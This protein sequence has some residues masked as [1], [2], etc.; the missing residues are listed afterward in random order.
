MPLVLIVIGLIMIVTGAQN[1]HAQFAAQVRSD[2]TGPG[3]FVYW[4]VSIG[5]VGSIGYIPKFQSFSRLF[6]ALIIIAFVLKNGGFIDKL[7]EFLT[8]GAVAPPATPSTPTADP[9]TSGIGNP[10]ISNAIPGSDTIGNFLR[11]LKIPG[12]TFQ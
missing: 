11:G 2:F 3:N 1:T 8:Q 4:V 5:V 10:V 6:L 12:I 7:R 9:A